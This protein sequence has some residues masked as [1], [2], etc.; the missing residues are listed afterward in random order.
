M[1]SSAVKR[2]LPSTSGV[3]SPKRRLNSR[4][5][6]IGS[7]WPRRRAAWPTSS[8]PASSRTKTIDGIV[9]AWSLSGTMSAATVAEHSRH[10]ARR[11]EVDAEHITHP[12]ADR[13]D[14]GSKP[15]EPTDVTRWSAPLC[16]RRLARRLVGSMFSLRFLPLMPCQMPRATWIGLRGRRARRSGGRTSPGSGTRCRAVGGSAGRTTPRCRVRRRP[17]RC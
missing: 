1:S 13:T 16:S 15:P 3:A 6:R 7:S 2:E 8:P 5:S 17:R 9:A 11:T 14:V 4:A 10:G 12:L